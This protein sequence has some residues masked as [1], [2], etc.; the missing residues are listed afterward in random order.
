MFLCRGKAITIKKLII[1]NSAR[2]DTQSL[3]LIRANSLT[4]LWFSSVGI[5]SPPAHLPLVV[6]RLSESPSPSQSCATRCQRAVQWFETQPQLWASQFSFSVAFTG[7][8]MLSRHIRWRTMVVHSSFVCRISRLGL[9]VNSPASDLRC[10][11][12]SIV[13]TLTNSFEAHRLCPPGFWIT[14]LLS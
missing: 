9:I 11:L 7:L 5:P 8:F 1:H 3:S 2:S 14:R 4:T 6:S 12:E 10:F 13:L